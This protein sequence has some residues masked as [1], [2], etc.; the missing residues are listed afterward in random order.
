MRKSKRIPHAEQ[1]EKL[2][3]IS[4][5]TNNNKKKTSNNCVSQE[6]PITS[7]DQQQTNNSEDADNRKLRMIA[8][9]LQ[10]NR[11]IRIYKPKQPY[12]PNFARRGGNV[13]C[14]GQTAILHNPHFRQRVV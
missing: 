11:T 12:K 6:N 13:E 5:Y 10:N 1:T 4:Y 3:G 9:K 14:Q 2:G 7:P 8:E